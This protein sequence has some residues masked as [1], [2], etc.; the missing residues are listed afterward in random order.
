M[1]KKLIDF[2]GKDTIILSDEQLTAV[3]GGRRRGGG[4]S[5]GNTTDTDPGC[6]PDYED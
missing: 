3:K 6:P 4:G 5:G 1:S 2:N